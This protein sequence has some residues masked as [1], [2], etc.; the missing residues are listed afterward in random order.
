VRA[1]RACTG[2]DQLEHVAGGVAIDLGGALGQRAAL[3]GGDLALEARG[4]GA[5]GGGGLGQRGG[6]GGQPR[7]LVGHAGAGLRE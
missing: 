7:L 4:G 6:G 2:P 5:G 3:D 1:E